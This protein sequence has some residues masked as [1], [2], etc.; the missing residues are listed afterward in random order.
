MRA[1]IGQ[2]GELSQPKIPAVMLHMLDLRDA[3]PMQLTRLQG[4]Q[5]GI[6][7]ILVQPKL[8]DPVLGGIG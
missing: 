1:V 6:G 4:R 8:G 2:A 7:L 5:T 3:M